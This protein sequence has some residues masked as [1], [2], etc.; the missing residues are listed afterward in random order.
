MFVGENGWKRVGQV[1]STVGQEGV[2]RGLCGSGRVCR[3]KDVCGG[4]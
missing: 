1:E 3:E 4:C 2:G